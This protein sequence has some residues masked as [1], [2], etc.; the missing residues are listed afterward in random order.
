MNMV[1]EREKEKMDIDFE[2]AEDQRKETKPVKPVEEDNLDEEGKVIIAER[3][4][5]NDI[6]ILDVMELRKK[7]QDFATKNLVLKPASKGKQKAGK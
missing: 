6:K 2:K 3:G 4:E 5:D 1:E 7:A